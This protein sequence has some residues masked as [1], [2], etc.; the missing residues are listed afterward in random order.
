MRSWSKRYEIGPAAPVPGRRRRYTATDVA[1]LD[2]IL[3]L[4][5]HG[6]AL[7]IA[8]A[9]CGLNTAS[10]PSRIRRRPTRWERS[11]PELRRRLPRP[12]GDPASRHG[13]LTRTAT[14]AATELTAAATRLDSVTALEIVTTGIAEQGVRATWEQLCRPAMDAL[15]EA[16]A[17][18]LGCVDSQL[19]LSWVLARE[20]RAGPRC[21]AGWRRPVTNV[22]TA[23]TG[24][25][26]GVATAGPLR[27]ALAALPCRAPRWRLSPR[28]QAP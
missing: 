19:L 7:P 9:L 6:I 24:R 1:E 26:L 20:T 3:H 16:I 5:G 14:A 12:A 28:V 27:T 2:A 18:D 10:P 11:D 25:C 4:V 17:D 22:L 8:G 23:G 13:A 15:D 21:T